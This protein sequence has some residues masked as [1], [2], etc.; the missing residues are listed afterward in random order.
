MFVVEVG[1]VL[2]TVLAVTDPTVF[3]WLVAAWLW[4][5]V[6][7]ANF[8]EA[9]AEGRGKAQADELRKTARGD[10]RASAATRRHL[11]RRAKLCASR[12]GRGR[13][14]SGRGD[15]GR[16]RGDRGNR[17][18]RR[19]GDHR[20]VGARDPRVG[21]RPLGSH[22]RHARALRPDRRPGDGRVRR[23]L[24]R[25][26]DRARRG[27]RAPEDPER[28]RA[29]YPAR[30]ADDRLPAR[31][32]H[33]AALRDLLRRRAGRDRARGAARLPDPDD[34]RGPALGDRDRRHGPARQAQ[35][36]RAVGTGGRGVGG[37]LDAP[38]RQDRHDHPRQPAGFGVPAASRRGRARACRRCPAL[39]P[40]G[41][42]TRRTLDR[43]PRQGALRL[44]R[45][46]RRR[47]HSRPLHGRDADERDRSQWAL[48][49]KGRGRRDPAAGS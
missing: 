13:R 30:R 33:P 21:R 8:A 24:P 41:R 10:D 9:V 45:A 7:F 17:Q 14:L 43:R 26:D 27:R 48:D 31:G 36:A 15:P 25:P 23:E 39:E 11:E 29:Q 32:R 12:R 37:L 46:H 34:D 3:A 42:D 40:R 20:R 5:T 22:R 47:R 2:V 49:P 6:L 28:G 4:F 19:V 16:R 35:R 1:S 38:P 44:A 18:R